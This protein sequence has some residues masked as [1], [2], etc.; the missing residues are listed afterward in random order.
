MPKNGKLTPQDEAFCRY[1][2]QTGNAT[3]SYMQSHSVDY[4]SAAAAASRLLNNVNI[5][6]HI[7]ELKEIDEA[8]RK[9]Q[10]NRLR[11]ENL[12]SIKNNLVVSDLLKEICL[13]F[14]QKARRKDGSY[15]MS[16]QTLNAIARA[17][18]ASSKLDKQAISD[19]ILMSGLERIAEEIVSEV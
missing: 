2:I 11:Q 5:Q 19:L 3:T 12:K 9:I 14:A 18:E 13:C 17:A 6:A 16:P 15:D 8:D 7:Q 10:L 1:Y 4:N